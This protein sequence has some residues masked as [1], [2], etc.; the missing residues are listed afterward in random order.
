MKS[1]TAA[2]GESRGACGAE[3]ST[4]A[5]QKLIL[6]QPSSGWSFRERG[7]L[8]G[9]KIFQNFEYMVILFIYLFFASH[10]FIPSLPAPFHFRDC[11]NGEDW[12]SDFCLVR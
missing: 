3:E 12:R 5:S 4:Y 1:K 9:R 8:R 6:T 10:I 2:L 7:Y 11:P